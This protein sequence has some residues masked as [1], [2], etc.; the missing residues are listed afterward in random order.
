MKIKS[1]NQQIKEEISKLNERGPDKYLG[2]WENKFN[3][4]MDDEGN[5]YIKG[6]NTNWSSVS[7]TDGDGKE[8]PR[9]DIIDDIKATFNRMSDRDF[10]NQMWAKY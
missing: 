1:L 2:K 7:I 9:Q 5:V 4:Y 6:K 10:K 8:R 3:K